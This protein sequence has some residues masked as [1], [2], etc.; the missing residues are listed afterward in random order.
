MPAKPQSAAVLLGAAVVF[1]AAAAARAAADEDLL[2]SLD[3]CI[4]ATVAREE[5]EAAEEE[6]E[7]DK[8]Y[9]DEAVEDAAEG[10]D[11]EE[12]VEPEL[13]ELESYC[14]EVHAALD[15]SSLAPYLEPDWEY[16]ISSSKLERLRSLLAEPPPAA[17]RTLDTASIAEI[18]ER[19]RTS[20]VERERGLWQR[21]KDWVRQLFD[22]QAQ[23][24]DTA[25][26]EDWLRE[27]WPS[28]RVMKVIAY[29]ILALLVGGLAWIVWMEL[30]AA[31]VLGRRR[32]AAQA[33]AGSA[34]TDATGRPQSLAEA[35][36]AEVPGILIGMLLEQ[37]RRL[38]RLQDRRTM[39]NRELGRAVQFDSAADGETFLGLLRLSE[40]LRYAPSAPPTS[41]VRTAV[42]GAQRLLAALTRQPVRAA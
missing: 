13:S 17:A 35:S 26:L 40:H 24:Q 14:P 38:G 33:P 16:R 39:T 15:D 5:A 41:S 25:W 30:R 27:N 18:V 9:E 34:A 8:G 31:G 11:S 1:F 19:V 6:D 37:L 7:Y 2:L 21:F 10:D 29:G 12:A 22:Q 20:Q 23:S 32:R 42:D 28:D 4:A 36:D 3:A